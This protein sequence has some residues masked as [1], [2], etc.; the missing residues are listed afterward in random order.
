MAI[1]QCA[2]NSEFNYFAELQAA[3]S[4]EFYYSAEIVCT[5]NSEFELLKEIDC[6]SNSEFYAFDSAVYDTLTFQNNVTPGTEYLDYFVPYSYPILTLMDSGVPADY[7]KYIKDIKITETLGG[8]TYIEFNLIEPED[9]T[10]FMENVL[11]LQPNT[12]NPLYSGLCSSPFSKPFAST[13]SMPETNPNYYE[14]SIA[15]YFILKVAVGYSSFQ[16]Y[17]YAYMVPTEWNFDGTELTVRCQDFTV[18][19]EQEGQS[20]TPDIN[21][22]AGVIRSAHA[23]IR[24]ICSR[25]GVPNVQ[26]NFPDFVIRLLRR[27]EDKPL[28][29]IDMICKVYQAKRRWDKNTLILEKTLTTEEQPVKWALTEGKHIIDGSFRVNMDLSQYKNKFHISRT[30]P[31]GGIIGEQECIGF[32]CPGRTGN[33]TFDIAVNYAASI[34][35][36]TNGA[37]EDFVYFTEKNTPVNDFIDAGPNGSFILATTPVKSVKFTYRA[38]IGSTRQNDQGLNNTQIGG[39]GYG[40]QYTAIPYTPRYKVTFYGKKSNVTGIDSEYKFSAVD[41]VGIACL[42]LHQ[43]YANIEDAIIPNASIAAQYASAMLKEATRKVLFATL[44]TPFINPF[45]EPG[46]CISITDYELNFTNVKWIVEETEINFNGNEAMQTLRLS[47]GK[48]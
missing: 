46:D 23:T 1:I 30:S 19:L 38:N 7:T 3:S 29:W 16:E 37:I 9:I 25:Y 18:L 26:I 34:V 33:I 31:N 35:E 47:R 45:I 42:G 22:D 28:N 12:I 6:P 21:A 15:T 11:K 32:D 43:E 8:K 24:E 2:E 10:A 39:M 36:V 20:M 5:D 27:T 14:N 13:Q 40:Q 48:L 44:E 17:T 4:S 41:S